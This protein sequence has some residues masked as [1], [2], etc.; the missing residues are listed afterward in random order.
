MF[1]SHAEVI[2]VKWLKIHHFLHILQI[3]LVSNFI[4]FKWRNLDENCTN[5]LFQTIMRSLTLYS[6]LANSKKNPHSKCLQS[7]DDMRKVKR[8][9]ISPLTLSKLGVLIFKPIQIKNANRSKRNKNRKKSNIFTCVWMFFLWK[10][11][12]RIRF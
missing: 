2:K 10:S 7:H 9:K 3:S 11:P 1:T 5:W 4:L 6:N 12:V 8:L